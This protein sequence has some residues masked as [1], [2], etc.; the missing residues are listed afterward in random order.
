MWNE[1]GPPSVSRPMPELPEVETMVRGL[2][3]RVKRK[4]ITNLWTDEKKIIHH[5]SFNFF[6]KSLIGQTIVDVE[7][8]GKIIV[9]KLKPKGFLLVHPKMTGHC[10]ALKEKPSGSYLKKKSAHLMLVLSND[11]YLVWTDQRK[12][13]RIEYW[14]VK[15]ISEIPWLKELG[16]EPLELSFSEFDRL[17]DNRRTRVKSWL[18]DQRFIVGVGNIYANE[19]LWSAK[20]NPEQPVIELSKDQRKKLLIDLKKILKRAIINRGTSV[21]EY[22]DISDQEGHYANY[23]KVYGRPGKPC[24]RC[25]RE[26]IRKMTGSRSTYYCPKCQA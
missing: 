14:P 16:A 26:I 21:A 4:T 3:S 18:L 8:R 1:S 6:K 25:G 2:R 11:L 13:S 7:R 9:F 22:R 23:L 5:P 10:L 12:F 19:V 20:I 17:M 15:T 24:P